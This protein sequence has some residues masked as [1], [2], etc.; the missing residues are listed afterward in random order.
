MCLETFVKFCF[1]LCGIS[2]FV[3]QSENRNHTIVWLA[4][5]FLNFTLTLNNQANGDALYS[6]CG[7]SRLHLSPQYWGKFETHQTVEYTASLLCIDQVHVQVAWML[8]SLHNGWLGD[9]VEDDTARLLLIQSENFAKVPADS[10]SFAV[11][12]GSQPNLLGFLRSSFQFCDEF[13]LFLWNL[14]VGFH[15]FLVY[16]KFPL[17]QVT[18]MTVRRHYLIVFT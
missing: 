15:R 7:K 16:T 11:L 17:L 5:E 6:S 10:F 1:Y 18:D 12:I 2:I 3:E 4:F 14:I 9:F 13:F 8:N